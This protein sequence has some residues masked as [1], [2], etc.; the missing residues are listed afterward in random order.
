MRIY[1]C[2][3]ATGPWARGSATNVFNGGVEGGVFVY[4]RDGRE[5]FLHNTCIHSHRV[6]ICR[7]TL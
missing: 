1:V 4:L 2:V 7:V 3:S 6:G 5:P